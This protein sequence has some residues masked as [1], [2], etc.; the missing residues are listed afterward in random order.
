[1][2]LAGCGSALEDVA[3]VNTLRYNEVSYTSDVTESGIVA[4]NAAWQLMWDDENK[5]VHFIEKAT[6]NMWGTT[7]KEACEVALNEDGM[8][9]KNH[10][11]VESAVHVFYQNTTNMVE[12]SALSYSDAVRDG[13]VYAIKI[14]NG[15]RVVYDFTAFSI[16]VPVDYVI[17]EDRF[18]VSVDPTKV[19]DDGENVATGVAIAPFMCG[20]KN[21]ATDSWMFIPDGSGSIVAPNDVATVGDT[22]MLPVYGRDLSIQDYAYVAKRQQVLMPVYGVKKGDSALL[23]VIEGGEEC[24][25]INW[26]VGSVNIKYS[27]VYPTFAF[28]G[29][30][31]IVP[32]KGYSTPAAYIRVFADYVNPEV[33][34][35]AYYP[36]SGDKANITGMADA[37]RDY[38]V[39]SSGFKKT[40]GDEKLVS[41]KYVGGVVQPDSF[42]GMP[43]TKLF[44][45]TTTEQAG[46]MT[47]AFADKL[48]NDF[49]VNLVG[50]GKSGADIG[51][52][53]GGFT[54]D[55]VLGGKSG[56]KD[57]SAKMKELG[58]PWYMDFNL[59]TFKEG[60]NGYSS[61]NHGAVWSNQQTAYFNPHRMLS[62]TADTNTRYYIL[63]RDYLVGAAEELLEAV[64][65]MDLQGLS[66]DSLSTIAYSDY[67][68]GAYSACANMK[69]DAQSIFAKIK[70]K[71]YTYLADSP[72]LYAA[73]CADTIADSPLYSSQFDISDY[74]VPFYQLVLRGYVPMSSVSLNLTADQD[75]ALLRCIRAGVSPAYTLT[76]NY[77]NELITSDQS[78]IYGSSYEGNK[79]AILHTV[80]SVKSYLQSIEGATITQYDV[81]TADASITY[82]SNGV[83]A[84]VNEGNTAV[85]TA[86]GEV[87]AGSWITGRVAQ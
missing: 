80:D 84:V 13:D 25:S 45:L 32:P 60:S 10:V 39:K 75:E 82:F 3:T 37:Y 55:S 1:M 58:V 44:P 15:L 36:L 33:V 73:L 19:A 17:E 7:P 66:L 47:A 14:D 56:M 35:V 76:Y 79:E 42:L 62:R 28:R 21:G 6:G 53:G 86:Y 71:G 52:F 41:L 68:T 83:Y 12:E 24:A 46:E 77:D 61:S 57:L 23:A 64:P 85:Q 63:G 20:V 31:E 87:P 26:N 22:G 48:G 49:E 54:T 43:T 38:L 40:G 65:S 51:V 70:E 72:N 16:M 2:S 8:P 59:I 74:D 5:R 4:E 9:V 30:N 67:Q 81:L 34:S 78:F 50:F 29:Y 18:T 69:E 11:Q 27:S